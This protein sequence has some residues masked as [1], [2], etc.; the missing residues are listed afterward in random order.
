MHSND[1]VPG[2]FSPPG[3]RVQTPGGY[4][5]LLVP[6]R[7]VTGLGIWVPGM[8]RTGRNTLL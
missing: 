1:P 6:E 4:Y 7:V 8:K 3:S 2:M 5:V